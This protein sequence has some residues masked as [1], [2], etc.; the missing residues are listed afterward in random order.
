MAARYQILVHATNDIKGRISETN[1]DIWT[2][3]PCTYMF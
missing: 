2:N 3:K 1:E